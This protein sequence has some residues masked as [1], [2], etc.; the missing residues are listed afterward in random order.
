MVKKKVRKK[1]VKDY[2]W[3]YDS[4][5]QA[6]EDFIRKYP[7]MQSPIKLSGTV[8]LNPSV[9]VENFK[10]TPKKDWFKNKELKEEVL[11]VAPILFFFD[12]FNKWYQKYYYIK[13]SDVQK[14]GLLN[15]RRDVSYHLIGDFEEANLDDLEY[16]F[17]LDIGTAQTIKEKIGMIRSLAAISIELSWMSKEWQLDEWNWWLNRLVEKVPYNKINDWWQSI[18]TEYNLS[19][20]LKNMF[21]KINSLTDLTIKQIE[22]AQKRN[23]R[24]L[25]RKLFREREQR[26]IGAIEQGREE[27]IQQMLIVDKVKVN[28][29]IIWKAQRTF[30][31]LPWTNL[32]QQPPSSVPKAKVNRFIEDTW[33]SKEHKKDHIITSDWNMAEWL[34][35]AMKYAVVTTEYHKHKSTKR[36]TMICPY[37]GCDVSVDIIKTIEDL[38]KNYPGKKVYL[39]VMKRKMN[40]QDPHKI[41][42]RKCILC[43]TGYLSSTMRHIFVCNFCKKV[44][45]KQIPDKLVQNIKNTRGIYI[46]LMAVRNTIC[47]IGNDLPFEILDMIISKNFD[48]N[49]VITR[50]NNYRTRYKSKAK[51]REAFKKFCV[52][53]QKNPPRMEIGIQKVI[54]L[55]GN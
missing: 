27:D 13:N 5:S 4:L 3:K 36:L 31:N 47:S 45:S 9:M 12:P 54:R 21:K 46:Y 55:Y 10:Q 39:R 51:F 24:R 8:K 33:Y 53:I 20:E 18:P 25:K 35:K 37:D 14:Y 38:P 15:N 52:R 7:V 43:D 48:W 23:N 26:V 50:K 16:Y 17:N 41:K 42:I 28:K 44:S 19:K 2:V 32:A 29:N 1:P 40:R 22:Q 11:M 30:P 34:P 49:R 6:I